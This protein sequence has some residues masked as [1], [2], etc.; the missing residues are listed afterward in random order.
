MKRIIAFLLGA[1]MV[2]LLCA[3]SAPKDEPDL[4]IDEKDPPV[5]HPVSSEIK[6]LLEDM[7]AGNVTVSELK[8]ED[9][10]KLLSFY[11]AIFKES[12]PNDKKSFLI[13]PLSIAVAL[14][15]T[16]EGAAG[17]TRAE[18]A[19]MLGFDP[20]EFSR[21][22]YSHVNNLFS[23]EKNSKLLGANSIW[24]SNDNDFSV[25]KE[26]LRRVKD[27]YSPS[28]YTVDFCDTKTV[29]DINSWVSENTDEMIKE[30]VKELNPDTVMVLIN[31]IVFDAK[32]EEP[33]EQNQVSN[34][35]FTSYSK[36]MSDVKLMSSVENEY[37][38][39]N[40]AVGFS[41][42]Y[43]GGKYKFVAFLPDE[44][45]DIYEFISE[46]D[47]QKLAKVLEKPEYAMVFAKI[48]KFRYDY[49]TSLV[50]SL[51]NLGLRDVFSPKNAD[52]SYMAK[53]KDTNI[54]VSDVIHKTHIEMTEYGTKAAAVTAV[55]VA[56]ATG[57]SP[58][59]IRKV[60]ITLDR[61]FVYMIVE[62]ETNL[63]VFI[64]AVTEIQ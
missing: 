1:L 33:Y 50:E 32:W 38:E 29:S 44:K 63:P 21:V 18:F 62:T 30:I 39:Y 37:Y 46:M 14:G 42:Y 16:A 61:P 48:P 28:L 9:L 54:Y 8:D 43:E 25:N 17:E 27:Y 24:Y 11:L 2:F 15:M 35:K 53:Y 19:E 31:T 12:I 56:K 45:D 59:K 55:F 47:S 36:E 7:T 51:K 41:K 10:E 4:I 52:L 57:A 23:N 58:N 26:Y 6:D 13:S 49:D 22:L 34:G 64:G 5:Y 60:N 20:E 40:G 3:C